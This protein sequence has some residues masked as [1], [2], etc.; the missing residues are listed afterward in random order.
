MHQNV[1]RL[2]GKILDTSPRLGSIASRRDS[3]RRPNVVITGMGAVTPYGFGVDTLWD[4]LLSGKRALRTVTGLSPKPLV[5]APIDFPVTSGITPKVLKQTDR[6]VHF[7]LTAAQEAWNESGHSDTSVPSHRIGVVIGNAVGGLGTFRSGTLTYENGG[8]LSPFFVPAFIPN[9]AAAR[10]AMEF[11]LHGMN[12]TV[13]TACAAGTDA[14]GVAAD[15]IRMGRADVVMAGGAEALF[16]PEMVTGLM[17]TR[18][19]STVSDPELA[20][21]P[22]DVDRSGMVMGEGAA[23]LILEREDVAVKRGATPLARVLGYGSAGDGEHPAA[24]AVDGHGQKWAMEQTLHDA[25]LSPEA[26]DYVNAH[27]TATLVGDRSEWTSIAQVVGTKCAVSSVKGS[28][29]HLLGAAGAIEAVVG[30]KVLAHQVIPAT[31]GCEQIDPDCPLDIVKSP[32]T[33]SIKVA[34]SNSFGLGGQNATIA[35]GRWSEQ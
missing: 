6:F 13:S 16:I 1:F 30:V 17:Q 11:S 22:F 5:G 24:P 26:V 21:R 35:L 18:A 7:A 25:N 33:A 28:L 14:I 15:M 3:R 20:C 10:I 23:I 29:G 8:R 19:L 27:G 31:V 2:K 9:M 34:L 32:R 12:L 4:A